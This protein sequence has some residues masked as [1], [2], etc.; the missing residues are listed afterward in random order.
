M[1]CLNERIVGAICLLLSGYALADG[2][3]ADAP[4]E[5]TVASIAP[6]PVEI[7]APIPGPQNYLQRYE[8]QYQAQEHAPFDTQLTNFYS[9][10]V[11]HDFRFGGGKAD[12]TPGPVPQQTSSELH[13]G[14]PPVPAL[15][16]SQLPDTTLT[17]GAQPQRRLSLNVDDW[18]FS[19][20]ARVAILH[21]HSTG[22]TLSVRRGF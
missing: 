21:S 16:I 11:T 14:G 22:A 12:P 10:Q 20:T 6:M 9:A 17:I 13:L 8:F 19:A 4:E 7:V 1:A 18:V 15:T 2:P 3:I 5:M